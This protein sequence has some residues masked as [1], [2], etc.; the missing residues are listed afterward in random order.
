MTKYNTG[1]AVGSADP[2]D[3]YDNAQNAD[4][5]ETGPA[6]QYPDRL[7]V[8]RR[9]RAGM[10][11]AFD[12][13]LAAS[14]YQDMGTYGA[15]IE[16]TAYNQS[17]FVGGTAWRL[18]ASS[19]LP[20]TTT[21][22][23]MPEGGAFVDI[24]DAVLRQDLSLSPANGLGASLVKGASIFLDSVADLR[25]I[26]DSPTDRTQFSVTGYYAGSGVGGGLFYWDSSSTEADNG[27]TVFKATAI[28]TGR[29]KRILPDG[30][31]TFEMAGAVKGTDSSSAITAALATNLRIEDEGVYKANNIV[32]PSNCSVA[33][34]PGRY[35]YFELASDGLLADIA[36]PNT[37]LTNVVFDGGNIPILSESNRAPVTLSDG[38]TRP[39]LKNVGFQNWQGGAAGS[40]VSRLYGLTI[41]LQGVNDFD[42]DGLWFRNITNLGD[43]L[44]A[45]NGFCGGIFTEDLG[46][47]IAASAQSNGTIKNVFGYDIRT[48]F[49]DG[50]TA[51]QKRSDRDG[52]LIRLYCDPINRGKIFDV[53]IDFVLGRRVQKRIYK[54]S[55]SG[56]KASRI[57]ADG[58]DPFDTD[59]PMASIIKCGADE[60]EFVDVHGSFGS[61]PCDDAIQLLDDSGTVIRNLL[62]DDCAFLVGTTGATT[63]LTIDGARALVHGAI[64]LE[65]TS[66]EPGTSI[67]DNV[68]AI[69]DRNGRDSAVSGRRGFGA[70]NFD[71]L[72]IGSVYLK[73]GQMNV[74]GN[75]V[76]YDNIQI[77]WDDDTNPTTTSMGAVEVVNMIP[78][79]LTPGKLS[80]TVPDTLPNYLTNTSIVRIGATG[81]VNGAGAQTTVVSKLNRALTI[82]RSSNSEY[83]AVNATTDVGV[84]IGQSGGIVEQTSIAEIKLKGAAADIQIKDATD[85]IVGRI[86]KPE[87]ST[88]DLFN[89][90]GAISNVYVERVFWRP[91]AKTL[92]L[93]AGLTVI[94]EI[95]MT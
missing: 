69:Y 74:T 92:G 14:G 72:I 73:N 75:N 31:I 90:T 79:N 2:R 83:G 38:A 59:V 26:E 48:R 19:S 77:E 86:I 56:V 28:T 18:A 8:M 34:R 37:T 11:K 70:E 5:L 43:G 71:R 49:P 64:R 25:A 15:G 29:F 89:V 23:G 32:F 81:K 85:V 65:N 40:L 46:V 55:L 58:R 67:I 53:K 41:D 33:G 87:L 61:Y 1:N 30:S 7:G 54:G 47:D 84:E 16:L 57:F 36:N 60:C 4:Y 22:A 44:G 50:L 63:N 95:Q 9:S 78:V 66:I 35:L 93:A 94:D 3:L 88:V 62:V 42:L 12:D 45:N 68:V 6:D 80:V 17:F 91:N 52:D 39:R 76:S 51:T 10:G 13:F 24:G 21:G 82:R 27:V 20:Y